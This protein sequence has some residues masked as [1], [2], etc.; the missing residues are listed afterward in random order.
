MFYYVD[1]CIPCEPT[2]INTNRSC[3]CS[4]PNILVRLNHIDKVCILNY[5]A[6]TVP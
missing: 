2:F 6:N 3:T 1:R 5:I 4:E